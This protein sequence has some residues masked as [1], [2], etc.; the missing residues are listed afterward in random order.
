MTSDT[1]C[2]RAH[3]T[4]CGDAKQLGPEIVSEE[5]RGEDMDV[6]FLER[7]EEREVYRLHEASRE[8][9][10]E[11]RLGTPFVDLVRNYRSTGELLCLPS[12]LVSRR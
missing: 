6:S 1:L 9:R 10:G 4:I 12:T 3:V 8:R 7:L 5:A 11:W 2:R